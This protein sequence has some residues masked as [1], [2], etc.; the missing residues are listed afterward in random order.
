MGY[1]VKSAFQT[2]INNE[3]FS[4]INMS[5]VILGIHTHIHLHILH[6]FVHVFVSWYV[7]YI[8][9]RGQLS[10]QMWWHT[11]LAL[12]GRGRRVTVSSR[13]V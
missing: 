4:S 6:L 13:P 11:A 7:R 8:E 10:S 12:G 1:P 3:D 2:S 9:V 5:D